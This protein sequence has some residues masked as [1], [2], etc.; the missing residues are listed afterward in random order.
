MR[1]R[2]LQVGIL[3]RPLIALILALC[4]IPVCSHPV[5][6]LSVD[7]YFSYSYAVEF[8]WIYYY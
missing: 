1:R 5:A 3:W 6:A 2:L 8:G 4:L 7:D